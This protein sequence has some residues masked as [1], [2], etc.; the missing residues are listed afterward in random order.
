MKVSKNEKILKYFP[1][2]D[3]RADLKAEWQMAGKWEQA[4]M[5]GPG[6]QRGVLLMGRPMGPIPQA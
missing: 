6:G 4:A 2:R 5:A 1:S 3:Y